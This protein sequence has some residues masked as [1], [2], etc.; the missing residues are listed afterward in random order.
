[1]EYLDD[2]LRENAPWLRDLKRQGDG[3]R[4]PEGYFDDLEAQV[5]TRLDT[6]GARRTAP[7]QTV[8][9]GHWA[10]RRR[11]RVLS[12]LAAGIALAA[13]AF[14]FFKA[15]SVAG[16]P[17]IAEVQLPDLS[18]EDIETYVLEN[19]QE[20]DAAQLAALPAIAVT[21]Q[22]PERAAPDPAAH[23]S[24]RQ[25]ALDD[26]DPEDLD[27]LLDELSNEDLESLL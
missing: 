5:F 23:R 26:L 15:P 25:Q 22:G 2:E 12:A 17:A 20:F 18:E 10:R 6:M 16:Q 27:H 14:W 19:V 21:D 1:M 3:L 8:P 4:R 7:M 24:K 9:G 11:L 13:A